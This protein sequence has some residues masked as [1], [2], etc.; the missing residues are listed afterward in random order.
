MSDRLSA[1]IG[2]AAGLAYVVLAFVG[3]GIATS[4]STTDQTSSG[5]AILRDL[6]AHHGTAFQVGTGL[7]LLAF[8]ALLAFVAYLSSVLRR[9]EGEHGWLWLTALGGG[10]L[11]IAIK[12]SSAA[13]ILAAVWRVDELDPTTARTLVDV[14]G[15]AFFVSF[16]TLAMLVAPAGVVALRSGLLPR[17]LAVAGIALAVAQ[18]VTMAFG[19]SA[20]AIV[21]FV[22][23]AL[24][25]A[26]VSVVLVRRA[27][28]PAADHAPSGGPSRSTAGVAASAQS[29][30]GT[31]ASSAA[32]RAK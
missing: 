8:L 10:L 25:I 16:A 11:T 20:A 21:P 24:W 1:R 7:E 3:N 22:L 9:A 2:A 12:L 17:P 31:P 27:G 30:A 32:M 23:S 5:A 15:F 26:V 14:N 18:L 28:A 13:P 6:Q 19:A 29:G 4:G